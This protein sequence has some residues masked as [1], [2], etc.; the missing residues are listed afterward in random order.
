MMQ[1]NMIVSQPVKNDDMYQCHPGPAE[2]AGDYVLLPIQCFQK[3]FQ[4]IIDHGLREA[5]LGQ[6]FQK[7]RFIIQ[8]S[9][10][11]IIVQSVTLLFF[12]ARLLHTARLNIHIMNFV[13][14]EDTNLLPFNMRPLG[15]NMQTYTVESVCH[16]TIAVF[17][18]RDMYFQVSAPL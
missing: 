16:K 14:D 5:P 17:E 2:A 4:C 1:Y 11:E 6:R 13:P 7:N 8:N 3:R 9:V 12:T 18:I 15:E 10:I